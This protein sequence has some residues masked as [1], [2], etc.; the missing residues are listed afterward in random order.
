MRSQLFGVV[1]FDPPT[2]GL[3]ALVLLS[4]AAAAS[5]LP[6]LRAARLDPG[7]TLRQG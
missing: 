5:Y 2:L 6:A 4:S 3:V 1:F 7:V